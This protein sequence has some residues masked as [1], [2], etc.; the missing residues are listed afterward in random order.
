MDAWFG[1]VLWIGALAFVAALATERLVRMWVTL[2]MLFTAVGLLAG[3]VFGL[4][5][6]TWLKDGDVLRHLLQVALVISVSAVGMRFPFERFR[7]LFAPICWLTFGGMFLALAAG[8]LLAWWLLGWEFATALLFGALLTPTDP[9]L[10]SATVSGPSARRWLEPRIRITLSG[11]SGVNDGLGLPFVLIAAAVSLGEPV[12][13]VAQVAWRVIAWETVVAAVLGF[14]LGGLA[15]AALD[16][17]ERKG[18]T[19]RSSELSG[20]LAIALFVLGLG[21]AWGLN[22]VIAAF[23]AGLGFNRFSST[24]ER[25]EEE[26]IQ[27]MVN[28]FLAAPVFFLLGL[29]LPLEDWR[30]LGLSAPFALAAI[31]L[32]RRAT[33]LAVLAPKLRQLGLHPCDLRFIGW[34]GPAGVSSLYYALDLKH[35]G[36]LVPELWAAVTLVASLSIL[37]HGLSSHPLSKRHARASGR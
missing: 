1:F 27:E 15:G 21:H 24:P 36:E 37:I 14:G 7:Q 31:L 8:T 22:P 4:F 23:F 5:P 3:P 33:A 26:E 16:W 10:A 12:S 28:H 32:L 9:V 29:Q 11:E 13:E 19:E 34:F 2:P 6:G 20:L 35:K 17:S 25:E 30:S 18:W